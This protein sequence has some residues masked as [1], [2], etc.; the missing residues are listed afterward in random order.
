MRMIPV[1]DRHD[2]AF[3]LCGFDRRNEIAIVVDPAWGRKIHEGRYDE[4]A[5]FTR[6]ALA[7]LS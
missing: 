4:L 6:E 7:S 2:D 1:Y 3:A 5:S